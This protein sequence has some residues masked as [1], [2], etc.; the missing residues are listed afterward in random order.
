M[1]IKILLADDHAIFREGLRS[2]IEKEADLSV[3]G[4]AGTGIEAVRLVEKLVPD[5]VIMDIAMPDMNGIEA[6]RIIRARRCDVKVIALSTESDRRF[7]VE[8]LDSGA[9]GYVLKDAAFAE[10]ATAI[11]TVAGNDTYLGPRITE[12]IIK[13]YLQRIPDRLPL[14]F[15]SLTTRER[16]ILQEIASGKSTK[17]IAALFS[18]SIKTIE[19]QR[20]AIMKK[21][22]LY[23]VAELTKYAVREG[24]TSR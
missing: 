7:I 14:T 22:N 9:N 17:E 5:V 20:H 4:E 15:E 21:L 10:L 18:V 24:L 3:A 2:L 19:V 8:V 11:R 1:S 13:D 12:L 23:S 16:E 6:T